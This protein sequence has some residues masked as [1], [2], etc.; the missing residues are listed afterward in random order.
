MIICIFLESQKS[1]HCF[2][3]ILYYL[4][5]CYCLFLN[6]QSISSPQVL[7]PRTTVRAK[8]KLHST[9]YICIFCLSYVVILL[10]MTAQFKSIQWLVKEGSH[11]AYHCLCLYFAM[12]CL[13]NCVKNLLLHAGSCFLGIL[14]SHSDYE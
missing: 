8:L 7:E 9:S 5:F 4:L 1:L 13:F 6:F 3:L 14:L 2:F 10:N 11:S 12:F